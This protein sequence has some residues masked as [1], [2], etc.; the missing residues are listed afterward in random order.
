M[1]SRPIATCSRPI[2]I[3]KDLTLAGDAV[4]EPTAALAASSAFAEA[5]LAARN[6]AMYCAFVSVAGPATAYPANDNA[7]RTESVRAAHL[8]KLTPS[9]SNGW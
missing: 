3:S 6:F 7:T 1:N 8:M 9:S 5:A 4:F 2:A